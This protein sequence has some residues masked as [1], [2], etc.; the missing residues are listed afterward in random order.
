MTIC[1]VSI[2]ILQYE[3]LGPI[4]LSEW[5]PP[6]GDLVYLVMSKNKDRFNILYVGD[7]SYTDDKAFFIQHKQFKCWVE[8]AGTDSALHLAVLP[9]KDNAKQRQLVQRRILSTYRPLCNPALDAL[10][11]KPSYRVRK[12]TDPD[13][14][15]DNSSSDVNSSYSTDDSSSS[16]VDS[17]DDTFVSGNDNSS[18]NSDHNNHNDDKRDDSNSD[19]ENNIHNNTNNNNQTTSSTIPN[20][21]SN[22]DLASSTMPNTIACPC[23]GSD[24]N[25]ENKVGENSV[26]YRC[27]DC[28]MSETRLL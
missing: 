10:E 20:T 21:T 18:S 7:C 26:L 12:M 15:R 22:D 8:K 13:E 9:L 17:I 2:Q 24:M 14:K 25:L 5:G 1:F 6:M 19:H 28:S 11:K 3:F 23:C 16:T 27:A 4:P